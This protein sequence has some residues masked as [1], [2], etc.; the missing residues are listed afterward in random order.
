MLCTECVKFNLSMS[1]VVRDEPKLRDIFD[2]NF[3]YDTERRRAFIVGCHG[4]LLHEHMTCHIKIQLRALQLRTVSSECNA[5]TDR[6]QTDLV[7]VFSQTK[8]KPEGPVSTIIDGVAV[9][10]NDTG[11]DMNPV[12]N[13]MQDQSHYNV[14]R[15]NTSL[16]PWHPAMY[17]QCP[18]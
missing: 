17:T 12:A 16:Q 15:Y 10:P 9:H 7:S 8:N 1:A 13:F 14:A 4:F 3:K 18:M 2:R 11:A 6:R 5:V